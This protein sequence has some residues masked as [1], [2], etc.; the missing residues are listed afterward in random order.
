[1][2]RSTSQWAG[3]LTD[4]MFSFQANWYHENLVNL[5]GHC[6]SLYWK[7]KLDNQTNKYDLKVQIVDKER[8]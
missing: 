7:Y 4:E 8:K 2:V 3:N 5:K 1:M 6:N